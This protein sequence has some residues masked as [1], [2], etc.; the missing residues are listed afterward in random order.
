M[1]LAAAKVRKSADI[2]ND[3]KQKSISKHKIWLQG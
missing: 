3:N 1:N 2:Q